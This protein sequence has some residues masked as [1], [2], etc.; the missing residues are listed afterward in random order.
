MKTCTER[1]RL[2]VEVARVAAKIDEAG[3]DLPY[4]DIAH[5]LLP[6][7]DHPFAVIGIV[8][9]ESVDLAM[10]VSGR[11]SPVRAVRE[12]IAILCSPSA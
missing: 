1:A 12:A 11:G 3:D 2:Q 4:Q 9:Q 10:R 7:G 5:W 8:P 6:G